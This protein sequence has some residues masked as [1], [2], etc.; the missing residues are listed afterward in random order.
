M[1]SCK[2]RGVRSQMAV[3]RN[4]GIFDAYWGVGYSPGG[5]SFTSACVQRSAACT[6]L[7]QCGRRITDRGITDALLRYQSC[8]GIRVTVCSRP[9]M[10]RMCREDERSQCVCV[11]EM[12]NGWEARVASYISPIL[13]RTHSQ[14][15]QLLY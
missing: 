7:N 12:P 2:C 6:S 4:L 1:H 15:L 13:T 3:V 9:G 11:L 8:A 5:S 14:A 10:Q